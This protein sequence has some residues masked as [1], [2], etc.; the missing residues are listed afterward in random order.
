MG[1][2]GEFSR[3]H[4]LYCRLTL[5]MR[6]TEPLVGIAAFTLLNIAFV[7]WVGCIFIAFR[8]YSTLPFW[9]YA[10]VIGGLVVDVVGSHVILFQAIRV[11]ESAC[12]IQA[13]CKL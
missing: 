6:I 2:L 8:L 9:M 12:E 5:I 11:F 3:L 4:L 10:F 7:V 13:I 1:R